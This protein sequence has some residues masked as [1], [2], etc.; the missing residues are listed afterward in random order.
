MTA[1]VT[2]RRR[3]VVLPTYEPHRPDPNPMFLEKRVYQGSSGRVY[4]LPCT[5]RIAETP[6]PRGWRA[7]FLE[8]EYLRVMLLPEL[9][10]RIHRL[11]DKT[12]GYDAIY[13]QPVIKPALVG[14]AGPWCSGGIEFNWPQHHRPS[15]FMPT[16]VA[17][18][19]HAD[20]SATVWMGEHDPLARMKGMHGVRLHPGRSVVELRA[21]A[22]NRTPDVQTFLWW[23]NAAT[24]VHEGYQSF[25]PPDA[26]CVAD[27]AKRAMTAFPHASGRYYG[28]DYAKR[29]REGIPANEVPR[30][31]VPP[32][33]PIK[34]PASKI[35]NGPPHYRPDD[36]SWYANIP[37]PTS[38]MVMGSAGDFFGGYDHQARAG[39]I[40]VADHHIAPGKKQWTW[41]NHDFGYAWDRNLTDPDAR[42]ECAP[43]LELMAGVFTDNQPDFSFLQPGETKTWSQFWYPFR[44][45]GP[46]RHANTDAAVSLRA[47]GDTLQVGVAVTARHPRATITLAAIHDRPRRRSQSAATEGRLA[48]FVRDLAPDRPFITSLKLPP[49]LTG[50]F[51]LRVRSSSG[52]ELLEYTPKSVAR[53]DVPPPATEPPAPRRVASN[54]ELF[55]IGLHLEQYRH[56]TRRAEDYW[57]EALRRDPGDARCRLALGRW[58]LRRGEFAAAE[59]HLRAGIARLTSRN[60]NPY[61]GEAH[62]QL[63][64]CLR[65]RHL[66]GDNTPGLLAGAYAAFHKATWNHA[67]QAAGFHALA[68]IDCCRHDWAGA[69]DHLDRALRVNADNLRARN[70][71]TIVLRRLGRTREAAALLTETLR[72]DPLDW[73]ARHLAGRSLRCD[74]QVRLDLAH[75]CVRAGLFTEALE[76][77]ADAQPDSPDRPDGSLGTRPLVHYTRAWIAHRQTGA[78]TPTVR[79]HLRAAARAKPDHCFP[80]RLEEIAVLQF[81]LRVHPR[82]AR[83]RF[84]LGNLL[85]DRRRHPEAI[86]CWE[87]AVRHEPGNAVAWR[88]LGIACHNITRDLRRARL[89]YER[90]V[91]ADPAS[92]R[93]LHERDQLWKRLGVAPARRLRALRRRR[94][95]VL[96]RDDLSVEFCAL[97]NQTGRHEE[98]LAILS[99][100]RFQPWEGGE[101]QALA[102]HVRTHL[103][104][105]RRA[106]RRGEAARAREHFQQASATPANLGEARHL[107]ANASDIHFWL[108][109][110]HAAAGD[111]IAARGHWTAAAGYRGDF[112]TMSVRPFSEMTCYS[113]LALQRLGRRK[114]AARLLRQLLAHARRLAKTP[115]AIDYFA[116][117]L[118]TMLLFDDDLQARQRTTA[119]LLEGQALLGLGRRRAGRAR[120]R[121]VLRRD[122]SHGL[123]ADLLADA[124]P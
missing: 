18:E 28:V 38:Y 15:T 40:H 67:W 66:A 70:L 11:L 34:H 60:P 57:R 119:R 86:A 48:S 45:I 14:L 100:R 96:Q 23:A 112:Q 93:Y 118:P 98:A 111:A 22:Y 51:T 55:V 99:S 52:R 69:H 89:A 31:F 97:C 59:R 109:C 83:A 95:L 108:G 27:H 32:H 19:R 13:H 24:R 92:A 36:L 42:G 63:G 43:Y 85:Y 76:V 84:Y 121:Q 20:G 61:D 114:E 110:A 101:G 74:N 64:L 124:T 26:T 91:R 10:G 72:L 78:V 29:A 56:A 25:F 88:N 102:Q 104:L 117:S 5:D 94:E 81:A 9:G 90:A 82:D 17:I 115:A 35:E 30:R 105:G 103:A 3:T 75:D 50:G 2:V 6:R 58:C 71:Q 113:A 41:G 49:D 65:Q 77:L 46:A 123:A 12:N 37:V 47:E 39:L 122:P 1:P 116:T 7:V 80:A 107:L 53:R 33:C 54:D 68:E 120:L 21:R 16:E 79:R 73:W 106:L 62:Y 87:R 8:N 4:P 44:E